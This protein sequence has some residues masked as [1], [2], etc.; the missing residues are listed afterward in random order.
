M[1][2]GMFSG[3]NE[4]TEKDFQFTEFNGDAEDGLDWSYFLT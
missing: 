3:N 4:S 1:R 2:L